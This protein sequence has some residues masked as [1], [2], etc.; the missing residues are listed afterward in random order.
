ML[1]SNYEDDSWRDKRLK[2]C[3]RLWMT[4]M[5]V[6]REQ[7]DQLIHSLYDHKGGLHVLW[8][9]EPTDRQKLAFSE[10]WGECCEYVV[11]HS[12]DLSEQPFAGG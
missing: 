2:K 11:Y 8:L 6:T 1:I 10:A 12:T 9:H 7:A 5:G 4:I 3:L